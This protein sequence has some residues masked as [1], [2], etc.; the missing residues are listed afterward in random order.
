M[1]VIASRGWVLTEPQLAHIGSEQSLEAVRGWIKRA[2]T[3][4]DLEDFST[5]LGAP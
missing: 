5:E 1:D 4:R 2:V 3:A